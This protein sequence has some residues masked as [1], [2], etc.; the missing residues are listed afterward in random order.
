MKAVWN[1]V[2]LAESQNTIVIEGNQYFPPSSINKEF[3]H[4]SDTSTTCPWKGQANYYSVKVNGETNRD[5]AW[6]YE[7]PSS[8]AENIKN[9]V[10]FWKGVKVT[11]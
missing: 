10:A 6:Y 1:D 4:K 5:A 9:Y 8:K 3:L 7:N 2:V 11:P